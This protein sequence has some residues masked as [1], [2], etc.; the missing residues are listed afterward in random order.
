MPYTDAFKAQM[1]RKMVGPSGASA[2]TLAKQVGVSQPTLSRWLREAGSVGA[3]NAPS[4]PKP[5]AESPKKWTGAERLR[6]VAEAEG[7]SGTALGEL[8]RREG[9]HEEQLRAWRAAAAG[10]LDSAEVAPVGPATAAERRKLKVAN[11][12]VK[13][14]EKELRRKDKALAEAAALLVFQKKL[15]ALGW[16]DGDDGTD[17]GS[18]K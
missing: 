4:E 13:E 16:N 11:K 17:E 3:M 14:L 10:A 2:H 7:L 6:V 9:L 5:P 12:R 15:Q 1:V 8:L 18:E